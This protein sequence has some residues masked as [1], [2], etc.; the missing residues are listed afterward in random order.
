MVADRPSRSADRIARD[1]ET[2]SGPEYTLSD[3]AIRRYAYT[4][5][6]R[7]TLDYFTRELEALGFSVDEDPVGTLVARNR[8]P[9]EPVFGIGSHCDSNRNGGR[10]DGT[11]GVVTA[12]EVCRLNAE[13]GLDL[14]LQLISF[15]EE[16]GSGFGQMLLGSRIMLERVTE[17]E[18]REVFRAI[19]DGRSFWEHAEEAGYEPARWREC[20]RTCSTTS[21]AGSRCTSSRP[22][23][24]RTPATGSGSSTRSPA[25]CTPTSS[26]RAAATTRARRRW[27]SGSTPPPCSRRRCSS[28]SGSRREAGRGTVG[29]IGEIEVDPSLINAI[30]SRVRFSLDIRGP[31]DERVR[32]VARE[33]AELRRRRGRAPGHEREVDERQTL[34]AT[35]LDDRIVG[36]SKRRAAET[37][38]PWMTMHS[39]AAHDTMCVAERVPSAM[40]FVPCR[41][42]ISH[43]PAEEADPADAALAAEVILGRSRLAATSAAEARRPDVGRAFPCTGSLVGR[44]GGPPRRPRGRAVRRLHGRRALG[45]RPRR[46]PVPR[47]RRDHLDGVRGHRARR[48]ARPRSTASTPA[49]CGPSPSI[50]ALVPGLSQVLFISAVRHA[51]PSRA[52]ILIGTAPLLSV[53]L[54]V[55]ALDEP[56][57]PASS[58]ARC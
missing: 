4:P 15:L 17:Q 56:V 43:H 54:A 25:T 2:L 27:A 16:E 20:G 36:R 52:A 13:H 30:A 24:S 10:Y 51:G 23:C 7:R 47:G 34:P 1:I 45:T 58:S 37:G 55:V 14:P 49:S 42:G 5:P 19:D 22:A 3:E 38:E 9:G 11:M 57:Q 8:P 29:T 40:V 53:A 44:A 12:L 33:I 28:W 41:D 46:R 21:S 6:Y 39:G 31:D 48:A 35:P 50:G 32:G 26:C 18:L